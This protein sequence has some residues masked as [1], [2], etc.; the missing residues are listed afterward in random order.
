MALDVEIIVQAIADCS[1]PLDNR[2]TI[3]MN[4]IQVNM[5]IETLLELQA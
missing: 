5:L 4:N 1:T 2:G 3:K